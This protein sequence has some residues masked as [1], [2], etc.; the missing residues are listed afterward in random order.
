MHQQLPLMLGS[1][2]CYELNILSCSPVSILNPSVG[3]NHLTMQVKKIVSH[4]LPKKPTL[5][6]ISHSPGEIQFLE[7]VFRFLVSRCINSIQ[8]LT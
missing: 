3:Q 6:F 8:L 1:Q 5:S 7:L 2:V 4:Q